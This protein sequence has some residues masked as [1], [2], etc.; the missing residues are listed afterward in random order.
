MRVHLLS[1]PNTEP[2]RSYELDGFCLRTILYARLLKRLGHQVILYGVGETDAPCDLFVPVLTK[3]QQQAFIGDTPYQNV[4]FEHGTPLH[5]TFNANAAKFIR[6]LKQPG[7]ILCT[8]AG[9]AQAFVAEWHPD[10]PCLE[11]SIGYRGVFAPNRIFQ[12]HAWRHVVHG[13][14]GVDGGRAGDA[15][16]PPWFPIEDFPVTASAASY[17]LYCGRLVQS[18]G[19]AIVCKAAQMAGVELVVIGHGDAQLVTY[20]NYLGAVDTQERNRLLASARAV[21]MPTQYVEPFGNVAA[22]AQL[23]GTPVIASEFGG[24]VESV[25]HGVSGYRCHTLAEYADAIEQAA[26]LNRRAIRARA[27]RL[28]S[29]DAALESYSKYFARM[30][31][32]AA[33]VPQPKDQYVEC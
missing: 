20:G 9:S 19:L 25:E 10:L 18:K 6:N 7:D 24:F 32:A 23:C 8:I 16:I 2:K 33:A 30:G 29:E 28:Y 14:S 22:E 26:S 3:A 13:F 21:L 31:W 1:V 15:V 27:V 4:P 17:V 11:Y 12:S 5:L